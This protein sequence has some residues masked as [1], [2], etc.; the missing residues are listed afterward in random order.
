MSAQISIRTGGMFRGR[1][2]ES[3]SGSAGGKQVPSNPD[4]LPRREARLMDTVQNTV[5][6]GRQLVIFY[7]IY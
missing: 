6:F 4:P 3:F 5:I 7:R 1:A 2:N